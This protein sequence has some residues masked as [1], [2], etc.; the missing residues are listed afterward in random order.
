MKKIIMLLI[1]LVILV[2]LT[3]CGKQKTVD[4]TFHINDI[5]E[6]KTFEYGIIL[7]KSFIPIYNESEIEGIY[8][9]KEFIIKYDNKKLKENIDVYIKLV[10]V[11]EINLVIVN[12][13]HK[14]KVFKDNAI[15]LNSLQSI[16]D[17]S[18]IEGLYYDSLF[19]NKYTNEL[20]TEE[21]TLYLDL[22][23]DNMTR[24]GNIYTLEEAYEN[25]YLNI[26][27]IK[28]I[29]NNINDY[30]YGDTYMNIIKGIYPCEWI[31]ENLIRQITYDKESQL[32]PECNK[33]LQLYFENIKN[34]FLYFG[35]YNDCIVFCSYGCGVYIALPWGHRFLI[36]DFMV[37]IPE[38][39]YVY[40][41]KP[42][43][44]NN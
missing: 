5:Q 8:Y 11:I 3:G 26:E 24:V 18:F 30:C 13:T 42:I 38:G 4:V 31:S 14:V 21:I 37:V 39:P 33:H 27:D 1:C 15:N 35:T 23:M 12:K 9:D 2:C 28:Q 6:T 7:D 22:N 43:E 10:D 17:T 41:W 20:I 34:N 16:V 32:N 25:N 36:E 44:S 40:V 19:T 29:Q